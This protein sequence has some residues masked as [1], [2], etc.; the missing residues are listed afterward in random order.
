MPQC[1]VNMIIILKKRIF[2]V[3]VLSHRRASRRIDLFA[4]F[5]VSSLRHMWHRYS[6]RWK[7]AS[8]DA[9]L[10]VGFCATFLSCTSTIRDRRRL[11]RS[12]E[13]STVRCCGWYQVCAR[14]PS[15]WP[16]PWLNCILCH[17]FDSDSVT[18]A[19]VHTRFYGLSPQQS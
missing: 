2:H 7:D 1:A 17:R 9:C 4:V 11:C 10:S 12:T 3:F 6:C 13:H 16:T 18:Y 5:V 15:R 19:V 14:T 8:F